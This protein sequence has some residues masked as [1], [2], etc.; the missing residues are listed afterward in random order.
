MTR[1]DLDPATW[2]TAKSGLGAAS[3]S[4]S[5]FQGFSLLSCTEADCSLPSICHTLCC[6]GPA[7]LPRTSAPD[8]P[9]DKKLFVPLEQ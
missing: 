4:L 1:R 9:V 7:L 2:E 3:S 6:P 5:F 8:C